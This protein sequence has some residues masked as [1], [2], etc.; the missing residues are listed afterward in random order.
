MRA[1]T[2]FFSILCLILFVSCVGKFEIKGD[3]GSGYGN[4]TI[5]LRNENKEVLLSTVTGPDGHFI[6]T[7]EVPVGRIMELGIKKK[8][9][10]MPVYTGNFSYYTE[11]AGE[12]RFYLKSKERTSLQNSFADL[13]RKADSL[14]LI[15][16]TLGIQYSDTEE[17]VVKTDLSEKMDQIFTEKNDLFLEG[18]Q[19]FS[20]TDISLYLAGNVLLF[21]EHDFRFFKRI[22]EILGENIPES[23]PYHQIREK[24]NDVLAKQLSGPAP[25]FELPDQNGKKI[26]LS[27][28]RGKYVLLDFWASWCA[29][30]RKKNK[31]LNQ[32]YPQLKE[33][34][35]EVISVSLDENRDKWLEAVSFDNISWLQLSDPSGFKESDTR[36]AYKIEQIPTVFLIDPEGIIVTK[37]PTVDELLKL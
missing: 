24:Y 19:N 9:L 33:K 21:A 36:K 14:D 18:M 2:L 26:K 32:Y 10:T 35:I 12:N 5:E 11:Q 28:F 15:N 8:Y 3:L 31:E 17:L 25:D 20:G 23:G 13:L 30:C 4:E 16:Q 34:N 29:P 6:L 22:M 7:G 37:N 27:S 1:T